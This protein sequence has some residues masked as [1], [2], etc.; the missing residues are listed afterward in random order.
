M[1]EIF[2]SI[3]IPTHNRQE[4]LSQCLDAIARQKFPA[5]QFEVIVV[6]DG[7]N[8]GTA[9]Y[10]KSAQFH[11]RLL[12]RTIDNSGPAHARNIGA[13]LASGKF[14]FFFEDDIIPHD[15]AL[16]NAHRHLMMYDFDVLEGKTIYQG[17]ND[18]VRR[19]DKPEFLSFIPCNLIIRK[20]TF[21]FIGGYDT[22]FY[23]TAS[24]LYFREDAELGFRLLDLKCRIQK[25]NDVIV[26]HPR[27]FPSMAACFR[28]AR[29]YMFDP[30]L[31][32]KHKKR[33]R[34]HIEVKKISVFIISRPQHYAALCAF[35]AFVT[36]GIGAVGNSRLSV[37]VSSIV[38]LL[39]GALYKYKYQGRNGFT[40]RALGDGV[41]FVFLPFV[42]LYSLV[43]GCFRYKSFGVLW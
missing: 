2:F 7:S 43:V 15:Q 1:N 27:Q 20:E 41:G 19:F 10:L 36:F 16:F 32:K 9:D 11:F 39:I 26:E 8:D 13:E 29:R 3:I 21:Q 35:F 40:V 30:L 14:L 17:S 42:Y 28:H 5:E 4:T 38:L 34:E 23:D 31:Y 25:A 22:A 12:H 37:V 6:N 18:N 24:G 33:F